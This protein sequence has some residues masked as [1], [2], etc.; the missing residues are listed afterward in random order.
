MIC[1]WCGGPIPVDARRDSKYCSTSHRQAGHRFFRGRPARAAA[2][3]PLRFAYA[4]PPYPGKAR[5]Y[6]SRRPE[7][8]GEVDHRALIAQLVCDYPD[9]WALS[10]SAEALP[11]VLALCPDGVR[12]AAW[13]RGERPTVSY[14]P[15]TAWEPVIY[16]GGRP[17]RSGPDVDSRRVDALAYVARIRGTDRGRVIGSKPAAFCWWLFELLGA[18]PGDELV[19]L[20][21]G[22]GGVSRAWRAY[23]AQGGARYV[24]VD[25]AA[26]AEPALSVVAPENDAL[27]RLRTPGTDRARHI[28]RGQ[29]AAQAADLTRLGRHPIVPAYVTETPLFTERA[30]PWPG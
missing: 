8:A 6:Y 30:G 24:P 3:T 13:L 28:S 4:D 22:S 15:L 18:L 9:G 14:R 29:A 16:S 11:A 27:Q 2:Q 1:W 17:L 20:F 26:T 23:T 10:T 7:F 25:R 5:R 12:V 19:D 21:P